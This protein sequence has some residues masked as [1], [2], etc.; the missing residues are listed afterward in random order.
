MSL[1]VTITEDVI[2]IL[3]QEA[4]DKEQV[5]ASERL[6]ILAKDVA[7]EAVESLKPGDKPEEQPQ[8]EPKTKTI[9]KAQE[10]QPQER[11]TFKKVP[12]PNRLASR[13][14]GLARDQRGPSEVLKELAKL[15]NRP[16]TQYKRSKHIVRHNDS[17]LSLESLLAVWPK[18]LDYDRDS[19]IDAALSR[20]RLGVAN[21]LQ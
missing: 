11:E 19:L 14:S 20:R 1:R 7:K 17:D 18:H 2:C 10:P 5:I 8:P 13:P 6:K 16:I 3:L 12:Q 9:E 4:E 15:T 21:W